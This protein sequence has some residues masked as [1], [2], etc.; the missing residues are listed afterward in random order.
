MSFR[1]AKIYHLLTLSFMVALSLVQGA[2]AQDTIINFSMFLDPRWTLSGEWDFGVPLGQGGTSYGN[3][4]PSSGATGSSV[5]GVN[6]AGDYSTTVGGPWYA[7]T[8]AI[9]C[10]AYEDVTLN[11]QRWLNTDYSSYVSATVEVSNNG[12]FWHEVWSNPASEL[13][14]LKWTSQSF[15]ISSIADG[16]ST[17]YVRWGYEVMSG[18]FAYSGWN[19]DD[20]TL[21][22]NKRPEVDSLDPPD[23][24]TI[25]ASDVDVNVTVTFD[26]TVF[27]VGASDVVLT[28]SA[29]TSA[30]VGAPTNLGLNRYRFPISG[31][32]PGVLNISL[33]G[34][35][36]AI[37]DASGA[38]LYPAPT[39]WSYTV[40]GPLEYR[41]ERM[42]PSLSQP[43]YFG[44]TDLAFVEP[45]TL[46]VADAG[47]HRIM[48]FS[49]T[50]QFL[51]QWG[52]VGSG[53]GQ[54]Q[55]WIGVDVAP[56]GNVYAADYTSNRVQ[57][58]DSEGQFL[59]EWGTAGTGQGE[60]GPLET[61][62]V[63]SSENVFVLDSNN[64]RVQKFDKNGT[65]L[66]EWNVPSS[67]REATGIDVD[68]F[69][70]V[71]VGSDESIS[72]YD[73]DGNFLT[74]WGQGGSALG[75]FENKIDLAIDHKN[76]HIYVADSRNYRIQKF[77]LD[78]T[79]VSWWPLTGE[80]LYITVDNN[81]RTYVAYA[82]SLNIDKFDFNGNYITSFSSSGSG[83]GKFNLQ[84]GV[85]LDASGNIY[86][87]DTLNARI[88][89]FGPNGTFITEWGSYG[90]GIGQFRAPHDV[91]VDSSGNVFVA[92]ADNDRIQKFSSSGTFMASYGSFGIEEVEFNTP[93]GIAIDNSDNMVIADSSNHRIQVVDQSGNLVREWG[94][95]GVSAGQFNRPRGVAVDSV[96][97]VYVADTQ[98]SRIQK[99]TTNGVFVTEWDD[100]LFHPWGIAVG[101]DDSVY[102]SNEE[103]L[104]GVRRY[105]SNGVFIPTT[106]T[107][108][109]AGSLPGQF[110]FALGVAVNASGDVIVSDTLNSRIQIFKPV[111]LS[112]NPKA[113]IVSGGGAF[114]GNDLWPATQ[115]S[116][117]FSYQSLLYQGFTE[118]TV[119]YISPDSSLDLSGNGTP[120]V[121]ADATNANLEYALRTWASEQLNGLPTGD[122]VVYLCDHG[123]NE[124]FRM[125]GTETLNATALDSW[126]DELESEIG[127][128]LIVVYDACESGTF[129]DA[130]KKNDRIVIT[131]TSPGESAYFL[132]TGTVSFSN[133]FWTQIFNGEQL[134]DAYDFAKSAVGQAFSAQTPLVNADGDNSFDEATGDLDALVGTYI[135][136][137]TDYFQGRPTLTG[138]SAPQAITDT[139]TATI[140][141]FGVT[142]PEGDSITRVWAV[143][144]P[145]DYTPTDSENPIQNL[146]TVDLDQI[147]ATD[148]YTIDYDGFTSV[149]LYQV[150]IYAMDENLNVSAPASTT[151]AVDS[152]LER[153]A[154]IIVGGD[155][156]DPRWDE[157]ENVAGQAYEALKGQGYVDQNIAF[158][159]AVTF[160]TG[161]DGA[162][163]LANLEYLLETW[164]TDDT[165]DLV[166][167][168][169]GNGS[170][171]SFEFSTAETLL[172]SELD[173]LLDMLQHPATGIPGTVS[174]VVDSDFSGS[175]IPELLPPSGRERIVMSSTG[176]TQT[177]NFLSNGD[178]SFSAYFWNRVLNGGT[179]R[180][181]FKHAQGAMRFNGFGQRAT[182]DD[183]GNGIADEKED[184]LIAVFH[185]IGMGVQ[186]AGDD[187]VIGSIG[188]DIQ[189]SGTTSA[190]IYVYDVTTTGTIAEV[191]ATINSPD[192]SAPVEV[193]LTE[194]PSGSG[195][196][197]G[198][199]SGFSE[200]G[201]YTASVVA[202]DTD[203]NASLPAEMTVEQLGGAAPGGDA[204]ESDDAPPAAQD[205]DVDLGGTQSHTFHDSGDEDWFEITVGTLDIITIETFNLGPSAD[206]YLEFYQSNGS[207]L[208]T[209]DDDSSPDDFDIYGERFLFTPDNFGLSGGTFYLKVSSA[210]SPAVSPDFGT[211]ATYDIRIIR[212]IGGCEVPGQLKFTLK[213]AVTDDLLPNAT[214]TITKNTNSLDPDFSTDGVYVFGAVVNQQYTVSITPPAGYNGI[215]NQLITPACGTLTSV[216]YDLTPSSPPAS[217][218]LQVTP[219]SVFFGPVDPGA[220]Q[221]KVL[222]I[223]NIGGG[224]LNWNAGGLAAPFSIIDSGTNHSLNNGQT[225]T[226]TVRYAPTTSQYIQNDDAVTFTGDDALN[227]NVSGVM[228][229]AEL[230]ADGAAK[231][232][233]LLGPTFMGCAN[234]TEA[235][236]AG[237]AQAYLDALYPGGSECWN[238]VA[239]LEFELGENTQSII[240]VDFDYNP[241]QT[242]TETGQNLETPFNT[243]IEALSYVMT[244]GTGEIHIQAGQSSETF[245]GGNS[246][247]PLDRIQLKRHN[248][249]KVTV[250]VQAAPDQ[251]PDWLTSNTAEDDYASGVG[252][253]GSTASG[254]GVVSR[255]EETLRQMR[256]FNNA[257]FEAVFPAQVDK[258][259][260]RQVRLDGTI[261]VRLRNFAGLDLQQL[262]AELKPEYAP[263][264]VDFD[265][266]PAMS[267]FQAKDVWILFRPADAWF[268]NDL[269]EVTVGGET[270]N[271]VDVESS[272]YTVSV[273]DKLYGTGETIPQPEEL[274]GQG[275]T[276]HAMTVPTEDGD[277][278]TAYK[279]GPDEVFD[280]PKLVWLPINS[281]TKVMYYKVSAPNDGWHEA[282]DVV[283]FLGDTPQSYAGGI[284]LT[285][286]H[287]GVVR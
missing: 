258:S 220:Y 76:D 28:G 57:K 108:D 179:V 249:G 143:V 278:V 201:I 67:I 94:A 287:G 174:V 26:E 102:V 231:L 124:T 32:E 23:A 209:T 187:P 8:G 33:A 164:G 96:G 271:G 212:E 58:F 83:T 129:Q 47:H 116:S 165:F 285:V 196:Y 232:R 241:A 176:D 65:Y 151:V 222:T 153:K 194:I 30:S 157:F 184:G 29:S 246:V 125:S 185:R 1:H 52:G 112:N 257:V 118:D 141:V 154:I 152:P 170:V 136:S 95:Q 31:L 181:A 62:A 247:N 126:L 167:Y 107:F 98:N 221:D 171:G 37:Q 283:G 123:G 131:S 130:L 156:S 73:N 77:D 191:V 3:P 281:A 215:A 140:N 86:V 216:T 53:N 172:A 262:W 24:D 110:S 268:L 236:N 106:M 36:N 45:G 265:W 27:G 137:G 138:V 93:S 180:N 89:K 104:W 168:L 158:R 240:Y 69:D 10:S 252:E 100:E 182:W 175:F 259:G 244:D 269:L 68:R 46:F 12:F 105:T 273:T 200:N 264:A 204:Y 248:S 13:A 186:L 4:D 150:T 16:R 255:D 198:S 260:Q 251:I 227:V 59:L 22:G 214:V 162:P 56:S 193:S 177:A 49:E 99:F 149:G 15:D 284:L 229:E 132:S 54:F 208:I 286:S 239:L 127:G 223:E 39:T 2:F 226:I 63:D 272:D 189:I 202:I 266:Q 117:N 254:V 224:T 66:T 71:Y 218:E 133:F 148:D 20:V 85:G 34:T 122:V 60:F 210:P 233:E 263:D 18:A 80:P 79:F 87:A 97:N 74:S 139:S 261:A 121:D 61:L 84:R 188:G 213:D 245:E 103:L 250:G 128:Q 120:D 114:P 14:D 42:W 190:T 72:K 163:S 50:G 211:N 169:V 192:G 161:V 253:G 142:D 282:S 159:S 43:W 234:L 166:L 109:G 48:K 235:T 199:Y 205:Y 195:D 91:A 144:R 21:T 155:E 51:S 134:S 217:P 92:D 225:E 147:G 206:T 207:T 6:L 9:N 111:N 25:Y 274:A 5:M 88:Q 70:N 267:D 203:G 35:A 275:V 82:D 238:L 115:A 197:R 11:F 78:G 243:L 90:L 145:P 270:R 256:T 64:D 276:V 237:L 38:D 19:L 17:V 41:F 183:N 178:I 75:E 160:S 146:P 40:E 242:K 219:S 101:P 81:G 119:Y 280:Q 173:A 228:T 279:I 7:Q 44:T 277:P 230:V 55:E 135:G 113:I